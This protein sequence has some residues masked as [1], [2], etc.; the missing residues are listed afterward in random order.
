M[1]LITGFSPQTPSV[2]K[3][4]AKALSESLSPK[5]QSELQNSLL[6]ESAL[7]AVKSKKIYNLDD[8]MNASTQLMLPN[9]SIRYCYGMYRLEHV[10]YYYGCHV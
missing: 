4:T 5:E 10:L 7:D 8:G 9:K 3:V 2:T 6:A 1:G